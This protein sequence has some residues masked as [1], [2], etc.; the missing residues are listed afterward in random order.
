MRIPLSWLAEYVDLSGIAP[1]DVAARLTF[2]GTEV[3]G[4][5][6]IGASCPGV[7]AAD[8]RAI[9][10]HPNADRLRL[11]RV[12]DGTA[13]M[14][15]VCGASNF[16]AGARVALA[17]LG[18][19]LPNGLTIAA[20]KIRGVSSSAM[21]CAADELGVSDDH[22][23]LLLLPPD[24]AP[25][26]PLAE[27]LG[28]PETVLVVEVT[29]NRPDCLSLIGIAR[30]LAALCGRNVRRPELEFAA[31]GAPIGERVRVSVED[32]ARCPRYTAR[33]LD[34]ARSAPSP[35]WMQRRLRAAGVRPISNLVDVTNYVMLECGQPLHAFD[36]R[37]LKESRIVVRRAAAGES[38]RT[39]DATAHAL[40]PEMLV[41][42]DGAHPVAL[43]GIMGGAE[44]GIA[45]DT[46]TV[47][48]ESA[49]FEPTG[50]RATVKAVGLASESS[51]RFE[52]GVDIGNCEWASRRA[53]QLMAQLSGA[54]VAPGV[55]DCY[56]VPPAPRPVAMRWERAQ[57]LL[58]IPL[59]SREMMAIFKALELPVAGATD[60]GCTVAVPSFRVDLEQEVDLIEEVAR[61]HGLD[62]I[63]APAPVA[64]LVPG[65]D[66]RPSRSREQLR[67][68]LAGL[69]LD[70][71]MNYS[72]VSERLL[73]LC[74]VGDPATRVKL[75]NP[76]SADHTILRDSLL[77]QMIET[78][79]RN[80]ARQVTAAALFEI[81]RVFSRGTGGV[82]Q[83]EERLA[84][85]L[86]G[87]VGRG[88]IVS[89][90]P[91]T[92]E[93]VFGALKGVVEAIW[94][95]QRL[96]VR[97]IA[98][99][100]R[101]AVDWIGCDGPLFEAG[102]ALTILLDGQPVGRLG[103]VS[104]AVRAEWRMTEPIAVLEMAVAPLL[105]H[106][107]DVPAAR[108]LPAYPPVARDLAFVVA[109]AV[110]HEDVVATLLQAAPKEL[111]DIR[112]FDVFRGD[113]IGAGRKSMAYALTYRAAH[114]TL[115]DEETNRM[116]ESV[117]QAVSKGL[118]AEI[119]AG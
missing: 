9:A 44:S 30:E 59:E 51:Y 105:A 47:L 97:E 116:H 33:L 111:V 3:E 70:E 106:A 60:A 57:A 103:V 89:R 54:T 80:K 27:V 108:P 18:V 64:R 79:G 8:V 39:L 67:A 71:A 76:I 115:T 77:P 19:T 21:L 36:L 10:K 81:G 42:A 25:G 49:C 101:P 1:T 52:R 17:R 113:A 45:D 55:L 95:A 13:E 62:K 117:M 65:A 100:R 85:G 50:I 14:E 91:V 74:Q 110:R 66:D 92:A 46:T 22:S 87:P 40:T 86:L 107:L 24:T 20:T 63:P 93:E 68:R 104:R 31:A 84:I 119:R 35:L 2:S 12:F 99:M 72:F 90:A 11:V 69:G 109:D 53:A 6:T 88:G 112:L 4:I 83:E 56:P 28:L 16:E 34:G 32:P 29:P 41:I 96:P 61:V 118:H 58:G 26:T 48:I 94:S 78:L 114:K 98:G 15:V 43:A 38:L 37:M 102:Q 23:G 73:G 75:P 82:Y 5:E 7:V